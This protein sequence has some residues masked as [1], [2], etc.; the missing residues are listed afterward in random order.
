MIIMKRKS[1]AKA[2]KKVLLFL[3]NYTQYRSVFPPQSTRAIKKRKVKSSFI[4]IMLR[5]G[6]EADRVW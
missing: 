6:N 5:A 4:I 2:I 3:T 1:L